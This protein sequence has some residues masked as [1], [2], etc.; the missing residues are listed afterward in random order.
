MNELSCKGI[1][2]EGNRFF[3]DSYDP[4]GLVIDIPEDSPVDYE[5]AI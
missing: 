2:L 4:L 1:E 5:S 3:K